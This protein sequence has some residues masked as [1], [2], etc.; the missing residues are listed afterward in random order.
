[1]ARLHDE[2]EFFDGRADDDAGPAKT[3]SANSDRRAPRQP[4]G[5]ARSGCIAKRF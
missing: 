1:M 5:G 4:G 3:W 2:F